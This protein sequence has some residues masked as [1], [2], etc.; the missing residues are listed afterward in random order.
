MSFAFR[1]IIAWCML[2]G[3]LALDTCAWLNLVAANE[4]KFVLHLSVWALIYE[5]FNGVQIVEDKAKD[6]ET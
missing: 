3:G 4:P 2:I 5:G 6:G 1:R